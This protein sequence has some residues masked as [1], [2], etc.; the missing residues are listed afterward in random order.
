MSNNNV[1]GIV[2]VIQGAVEEIELP[3]E[4]DGLDP[5]GPV[6]IM[7]RYVAE[8]VAQSETI[9]EEFS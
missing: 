3:V 4:E 8:F 5:D 1:D 7:I 6:D 9:T 2:T